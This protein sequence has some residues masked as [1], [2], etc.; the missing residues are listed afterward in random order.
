MQVKLIE[1]TPNA[2]KVVAR[3]AKQC[4]D[5]GFIGDT[6]ED[7]LR[8]S[9][10][11]RIKEV[12]NMGHTSVLE[13]ANYTFAIEG[14]SRACSHQLV[15]F[16]VASYSQQS[17]RYCKLGENFKFVMPP[18]IGKDKE[19]G[20]EFNTFMN[21]V[22]DF[23]NRLIEKGI[24]A[25]DARFVAPNACETNIVM[26]MNA[27]ELHHAFKLRCCTHAQWE[28]RDMFNTMKGLVQERDPLLFERVGAPCEVNGTCPEIGRSCGKVMKPK[29]FGSA[30]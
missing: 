6:Y 21:H 19:L 10:T 11:K 28:I 16:R 2:V 26:T 30:I 5:A 20:I 15:R 12:L 25:E 4:Y 29:T 14:I 13:H 24:P 3:A 22:S 8:L 1:S 9:D 17:Q 7:E 18:S 23:Y 27:R